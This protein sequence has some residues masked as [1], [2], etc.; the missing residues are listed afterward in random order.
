M[1]SAAS[2]VV[3]RGGLDRLIAA[4]AARG[5]RTIGPVVR[6][7]AI[8]A[9]PV[10]DTGDLPQGWH[11]EQEPGHYRL[12][13][14]DDPSLFAWAVGPGSWKSEFY[15]PR[16]LVW[17]TT[18][19]GD[20]VDLETAEDHRAPV[21]LIGSRPCE[22]AALRVLDGVFAGGAV[23]DPSYRS[24]RGASFVVVAECG[25]PAATCFCTSM[26]TGPGVEEG[27][28]LALTEVASPDGPRYLVRVGSV[29]GAEIAEELAGSPSEPSDFTARG[30]VLEQAARRISRRL[31]ASTVAQLL[32]SNL[33]HPRWDDVASRCLACGNC[34]LVCPTCF[35]G[36]VED[37]TE[38]DGTVER[39]RR[40]D[41]CFDLA[42]SL[43][44]SGPV[45]ATTRS[46]YRQWLTHKLST[47]HDQFGTSGCVGCG[48]CI[49][50][51][52]VG[53]DLT[54]EVAAIAASDGAVP[55]HI[56]LGGDRS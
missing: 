13:H 14:D 9:R 51:C 15:P 42:H 39:H 19:I 24:R 40:W 18:S 56:E 5:Y 17:R 49:T 29:R 22:L 25:S 53:I 27:Y 44:H 33:A 43:V 28:D 32:A 31:E 37:T 16:S 11:D 10:S 41:T 30:T 54:V 2:V 45:R 55:V 50:W 21:A 35:C 47:W 6:D 23:A 38:V 1:E 46:R 48:R 7:G 8:V 36:A 26:G 34:T 20:V 12:R 4:L 3:D 52:P